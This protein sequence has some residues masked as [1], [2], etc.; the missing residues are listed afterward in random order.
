M[1]ARRV[2]Y[3][4]PLIVRAFNKEPLDHTG[5]VAHQRWPF[6]VI[7]LHVSDPLYARGILSTF[8]HELCHVT[9]F[10]LDPERIMLPWSSHGPWAERPEEKRAMAFA[11]MWEGKLVKDKEIQKLLEELK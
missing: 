10:C 8:L 3:R 1:L 7:D 6:H 9:E 11:L 4:R 2:E 5:G